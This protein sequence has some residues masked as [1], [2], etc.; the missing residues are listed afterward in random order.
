MAPRH[1]DQQS[2]ALAASARLVRALDNP[3]GFDHPVRYLRFLET[4]I[5]WI[6]LTGH[7]AYKIKKPVNFGFLDFSTL[8][9]RRHYCH[10]ELRLNRRFAPKIYLDVVE[11]RGSPDAPRLYGDG[12]DGDVIEYALRMIEFPQQCLLSHHAAAG[13][14]GAALIDALASRVNRMHSDAD[15][16]PID[17]AYGRASRVLHWSEENLLQLQNNIPANLMPASYLQL[18]QWYRRQD[19]LP[20]LL[21]RRRLDGH[22]RECHGDLHLDN[23]ALI[24]NEVTPFD[25]IEFN[26]EL[27]WIDTI[28]EAAFVAMDLQASGDPGMCWRFVSRYLENSADYD[29]V[30][31]LRYY[32]IYRALVRAKVEALRA[33]PTKAAAKTEFAAAFAYLD[34]AQQWT[35]KQAAGMILMHGLSGSGKSTVAAQLVEALGAIQLRSD[36]IRKQLFEL[37]AEADSGSALGQGIYSEEATTLT[38]RRLRQ[39][40][41]KITAAGFCVIVDASFLL[42]EQRQVLLDLASTSGCPCVLVECDAPLDELRKRIGERSNDPSEAN[43]QVLEQQIQKRQP[44]QATEDGISAIVSVDAG[45]PSKQDFARIRAALSPKPSVDGH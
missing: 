11:I 13:T 3:Q 42:Q 31:L 41:Q 35:H 27:R 39:I 1:N 19:E 20:A 9:K 4:H 43:L 25:C 15:I 22:I 8:A 24:D 17:S 28:S 36:V 21:E 6:I 34:L 30:D 29:G 5:S 45:G 18:R 7:Y 37:A 10:E 2:T 14:L 44:V 16:A 12:D 26:P 23:I 32:V 38:Y 40:A 33:G